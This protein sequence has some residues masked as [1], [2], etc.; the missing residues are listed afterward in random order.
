MPVGVKANIHAHT[1]RCQMAA[2]S[3]PVAGTF[4]KALKVVVI[5]FFSCKLKVYIALLLQKVEI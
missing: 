3:Y 1:L 5:I 2:A 4:E